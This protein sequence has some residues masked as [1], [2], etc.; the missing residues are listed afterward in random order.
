MIKKKKIP[1]KSLVLILILVELI[2]LVFAGILGEPGNDINLK[3]A[4]WMNHPWRCFNQYTLI[5]LGCGLTGWVFFLA[6]YL[7]T[8]RNT[9]SD[10]EHG[11]AE[12]DDPDTANKRMADLKHPENN[13]ILSKHVNQALSGSKSFPN[14]NMIVVGAP[15]TGKSLFVIAPNILKC[16]SSYLFMDPKGELVEKYGNYLQKNGYQIR[17]LNL[18]NMESSD[19]Y[20]P[21]VYIRTEDDIPRLIMNIFKSVEPP[22]AQK[23]D[24]FWDDGCALYLQSLFY[25]VWAVS[26]PDKKKIF[27]EAGLKWEPVYATQT[28]NQV[29]K[30]MQLESK[31]V[32]PRSEDEE[33]STELSLLMDALADMYPDHPAVRDYRKLKEGAPETVASVLLILNGKFKFFYSKSIQRIF[34][35]DDMNLWELGTG[36]HRDGKS[37]VALFLVLKENDSS[38]NFVGNMLYQQL[39][40]ELLVEADQNY[41]GV[42]PIRV[43]CWMDEFGNGLRPE[44]FE[45]LITTLRSRNIAVMLFLQSISQLQTM[46][47]GDGWK[48]FMDSCAVFLFLGSGRGAYDT[49]ETISKMLGAATIEKASGSVSYGQNG[50]SSTSYDRLQRSL[51]DANEVAQMDK[52]SCIILPFASKP[53]I[54]KKYKPFHDPSYLKAK[55]Y[56]PYTHPVEIFRDKNGNLHTVNHQEKFYFPGRRGGSL[57]RRSPEPGR[58]VRFCADGTVSLGAGAPVRVGP[59]DRGRARGGS[60]LAGLQASFRSDAGP[61]DQAGRFLYGSGN[62]AHRLEFSHRADRDVLVAVHHLL[63]YS[64]R[65]HAVGQYLHVARW[66]GLGRCPAGRVHGLGDRPFVGRSDGLC[67][68]SCQRLGAARCPCPVADPRQGRKRLELCVDSGRG[69]SVRRGVGSVAL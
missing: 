62:S 32:P 30:L 53:I 33:E 12:W 13:R 66:T 16:I 56:G 19:R 48:V 4:S 51:M 21:F 34:E 27:A 6:F 68:Q 17:V 60:G 35:A 49:Q 24:P 55:K 43:E 44:G 10:I 9:H 8:H 26:V 40:D 61:S 23:G 25:F 29:T 46:Y 64:R 45:H 14:N 22:D 31:K 59:D 20:N 54:D 3:T 36:W 63:H 11:S 67:D 42:L 47:K 39:F 28:L 7:D 1:I 38:Y 50:S 52:D 69:T 65:D 41:H 58:Y 57:Q 18:K 37:K 2:C 15:G 5:S